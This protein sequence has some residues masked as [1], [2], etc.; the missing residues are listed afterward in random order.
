MAD[1]FDY[2]SIIADPNLMD[3]EYDISNIRTTT[4]TSERLLA[5]VPEYSGLQFDPTQQSVYSDLYS[6][7]SGGLPTIPV[8][9]D[10]AQIPGTVDTSVGTGGGGT[11]GGNLLNQLE[12]DAGIDAPINVTT[13]T[14]PPGGGDPDMFYDPYSNVTTAVAPPSILN[15][16]QTELEN[17]ARASA[18]NDPRYYQTVAEDTGEIGRQNVSGNITDYLDS[19]PTDVAGPF[20]YM[21]PKETL[22]SEEFA[23]ENT[24][25]DYMDMN[26]L[27]ET[28]PSAMPQGSPGQLNPYEPENFLADPTINRI[29]DDDYIPDTTLGDV[30]TTE[31]R[32]DEATTARP[33][34]LG[35]EGA[36]MNY[37]ES[38]LDAPYGVNPNTGE[39]YQEP[40]TI[41]DQNRVLNQTFETK[42]VSQLEKFRDNFVQT[43]QDIG[44]FFTNLTNEGIDVG[45]TTGTVLLNYLGKSI[46]GVPLLGTAIGMLPPG[47][48]TFQTQKAIE[49]GLVAPGETQDKYGINTQSMLGDYDQYNV[50]RVEE[51]E[52]QFEKTKANFIDEYG[53]LDAINEYGK[54]WEEMNKRNLQELE[55]RKEYVDRSGAGGDIQPDATDLDIATGVLTGDA[56]AAEDAQDLNLMDVRDEMAGIETGDASL[57]ERIAAENRAAAEEAQRIENERAANAREEARAN[58]AREAAAQ[59]EAEA[60]AAARERARQP[61]PTYTPPSPHR[62]DGDGGNQGGNT[63]SGSVSTGAGRNPWGR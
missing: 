21:Q 30:F 50:E 62:P 35:D 45:R 51:L 42:D 38:A 25:L 49:L 11:G 4:P 63:G 1:E 59:A 2:A 48:P 10:T 43:G 46:T 28:Q 23:R 53:S 16:E 33:P 57:A 24:G 52:E 29:Q 7:Y 44:N 34:M 40:R 12:T 22:A 15:Q 27:D 6:L 17:I 58:A 41:A 13:A 60:R 18:L 26:L 55:D 37:M 39:P 54:N 20:E 36:S 47:G 14:E 56:A 3:P 9:Q 31:A 8:A 5:A 19:T 61:A 32:A